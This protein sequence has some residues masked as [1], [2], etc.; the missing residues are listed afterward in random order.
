M[1]PTITRDATHT[2]APPK[3]WD[4]EKDGP[5]GSLSARL[6]GYGRRALVQ[7][8]STWKPDAAE[9]KLLNA[10]AVIELH[11]ITES[12]PPAGL[13]VVAPVE[14]TEVEVPDRHARSDKL[15]YDEHGLATP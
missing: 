6:E 1:Q 7:I 13:S 15:T 10:G 11:L 14:V 12:L 5:C 2:F 3:N 4:P 9:L 8:T